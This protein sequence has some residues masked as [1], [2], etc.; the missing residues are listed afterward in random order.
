[1]TTL[2]RFLGVAL[3]LY[4]AYAAATGAVYAKSGAGA[5]LVAKGD[6]PG[7]FWAVISIYAALSVALVFFF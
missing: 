1:M 7:Y 3:A 5:R 2:F 4:T 6:S